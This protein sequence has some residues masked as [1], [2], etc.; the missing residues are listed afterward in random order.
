MSLA[1]LG[2]IPRSAI[3]VL[4]EGRIMID[5]W[6]HIHV[7][8]LYIPMDRMHMSQQENPSLPFHLDICP[9]TTIIKSNHKQC[10]R[11]HRSGDV[12][13]K[14]TVYTLDHTHGIQKLKR[15]T[16]TLYMASLPMGC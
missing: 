4:W 7:E 9:L 16:L 15:P 6:L 14:F 10:M 3:I 1:T 11:Q 2:M 8:K 13:N 5:R 12:R